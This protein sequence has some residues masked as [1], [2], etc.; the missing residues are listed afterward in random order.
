[1]EC[2]YDGP[3]IAVETILN[4][5]GYRFFHLR[6]EGPVAMN[7]IVPDENKLYR[8]YLCTVRDDWE[9]IKCLQP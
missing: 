8:N 3:F 9:E 4:K 1:V 6:P 5:F 7:K 2:N